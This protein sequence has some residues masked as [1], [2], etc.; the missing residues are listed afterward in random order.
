MIQQL[1]HRSTRSLTRFEFNAHSSIVQLPGNSF[2]D[3]FFH[4][5]ALPIAE[6]ASIHAMVIGDGAR[7]ESVNVECRLPFSTITDY[8]KTHGIR[9]NLEGTRASANLIHS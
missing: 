2:N 8:E 1:A 4:S 9:G 3:S 5:R 6:P 7:A